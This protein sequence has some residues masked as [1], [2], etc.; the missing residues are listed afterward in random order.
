MYT[1]YVP[2][3]ILSLLSRLRGW[4]FRARSES[5]YS[6]AICQ[7]ENSPSET[8]L[9]VEI[10][11]RD[12]LDAIHLHAMFGSSVIAFEPEPQNF[13]LC[14][15]NILTSGLSAKISVQDKCLIDYCGEIDFRNVI[16]EIYDNPGASSIFEI[17]F[18]NRSPSDP[19]YR[20]NPVQGII[21]VPAARFD[22]LK[23]RTPHSVFMDIQGAE[24]RAL[25]GFGD[26]LEGVKN[27]VLETSFES[28]YDGG[29]TFDELNEYL[30]QRGFRYMASDKFGKKFPQIKRGFENQVE[31]NVLY[32][33]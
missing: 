21:K 16:T 25:V 18:V 22:C 11:S 7:L 33:K 24:L 15:Q 2:A 32:S 3:S 30:T 5:N 19:D 13:A 26:L 8:D 14:A 1:I 9:I 17:D 4:T 28:L 6:W 10:G 12:A 27:V 23:I 20:R 31:F 29:C